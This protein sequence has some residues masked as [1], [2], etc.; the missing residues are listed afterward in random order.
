MLLV[1]TTCQEPG[2]A[3][4][5]PDD[6]NIDPWAGTAWAALLEEVRE[7]GG[8]ATIA[9]FQDAGG[10]Q[11]LPLDWPTVAVLTGPACTVPGDPS[12]GEARSFVNCMNALARETDGANPAMNRRYAYWV[13]PNRLV[14]WEEDDGVWRVWHRLTFDC[15]EGFEGAQRD[16]VV[17][18]R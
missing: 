11:V 14:T 15:G 5:T 10:F 17:R 3:D 9:P 8:R 13:R 2:P 16:G 6:R 1:S 4:P 18:T 12:A 7:L